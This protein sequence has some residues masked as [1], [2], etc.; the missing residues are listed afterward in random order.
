MDIES[1]I[2]RYSHSQEIIPDGLIRQCFFFPDDFVGFAGH[3][4]GNPIL[5]AFVQI[6]MARIL[7]KE[8]SDS[9]FIVK[10]AKF[11]RLMRPCE[12]ISMTMKGKDI[13]ITVRGQKAALMRIGQ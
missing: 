6:C 7:W 10:S 5:P 1:E 9:P 13:E 3:F 12:E 8:H 4:P 11:V 2:L